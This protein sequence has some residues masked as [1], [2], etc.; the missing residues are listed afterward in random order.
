MLIVAFCVFLLIKLMNTAVRK[1]ERQ[2]AAEAAAQAER[3][4]GARGDR[5]AGHQGPATSDSLGVLSEEHP[6]QHVHVRVLLAL[7]RVHAEFDRASSTLT[8]W[9]APTDKCT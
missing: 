2:K 5:E 4:G 8:A 6:A 7:H 9:V 1:F 3:P